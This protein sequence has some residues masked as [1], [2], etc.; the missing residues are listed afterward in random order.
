MPR[1][2]NGP[3]MFAR[4]EKSWKLSDLMTTTPRRV[5]SSRRLSIVTAPGRSAH[6]MIAAS[7]STHK[8]RGWHWAG[9]PQQIAAFAQRDHVLAGTS[10]VSLSAGRHHVVSAT[11]VH[12]V[13]INLACGFVIRDDNLVRGASQEPIG[14]RTKQDEEVRGLTGGAH[15]IVPVPRVDPTRRVRD[16]DVRT[17]RADYLLLPG[18]ANDRGGLTE[19]Q[20]LLPGAS[21]RVRCPGTNRP[22]STRQPN[23]SDTSVTR[24]RMAYLLAGSHS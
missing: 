16:D 10:A 5:S 6:K 12:G 11:H 24:S 14:S 18:R 7:P 21:R 19:T 3:S 13:A 20:L 4:D 9:H 1:K 2:L 15:Q 22:S 17:L 8:G 23:M